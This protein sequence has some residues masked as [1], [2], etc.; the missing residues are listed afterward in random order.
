MTRLQLGPIRR[1]GPF[2]L[3]ALEDTR[4]SARGIGQ[5]VTVHATKAPR[6]ILILGP[7][8]LSVLDAQGDPMSEAVLDRLCPGAAERLRAALTPDTGHQDGG[9][10]HASR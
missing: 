3:A 2:A 6:A 4:L 10:T 7:G 1:H 9:D 5:V 8:G